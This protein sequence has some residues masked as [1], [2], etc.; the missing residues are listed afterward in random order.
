[1][2][3]CTYVFCVYACSMHTYIHADIHTGQV[4]RVLQAFQST[5]VLQHQ[6]CFCVAVPGRACRVCFI[7]SMALWIKYRA[8]LREHKTLWES[9]RLEYTGI[10]VCVCERERERKRVRVCECVCLFV[11]ACMCVCVC[12]CVYLQPP[13]GGR[14]AG[15]PP[16][17]ICWHNSFICVTWLI[18]VYEMTH[19]YV[20]WHADRWYQLRWRI[21]LRSMTHSYVWHDACIRDTWLI[22]MC[23]MTHLYVWHDAFICDMTCRTLVSLEMTHLYVRHDAF[24]CLIW[25]I[26]MRHASHSYVW[27][28]AFICV[29]WLIYMWHTM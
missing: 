7:E 5:Q 22:H 10:C 29:T 16:V 25:R 28:D 14:T 21:P 3:V 18:H 26:Y 6:C 11:C 2:Y 20:T 8:L 13:G 4:A 15:S 27:H 12:V 9:I 24:I 1:M 23:E 19:S 17:G